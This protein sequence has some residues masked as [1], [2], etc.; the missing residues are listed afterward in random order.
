MIPRRT[1]LA[2]AVAALALPAKPDFDT[3]QTATQMAR[4]LRR[5]RISAREVLEAHLAR[6]ERVNPK[7]NAIVTLVAGQ[8]RQTA[9][10]LD[11]EAAKGRF[12]GPLHGLPVA[13]KDLVE[14]KGI[15][16]TFGSPLFRDYVPTQNAL[17][18]DRMQAAGAVTI[19]KT[20]TPEFGAGSQT[21]NP[22]FG[23]TKNPYDL[24]KTSGGSSG[25][26][27]AALASGMIPIADGSDMG[28]SLRNPAAFCS[29]VGFRG[30]P[31]RVPVPG[32]WSPFS[33]LGPMGR[34][35]E[36]VALL[37]SVLAGPDARAP[38]SIHEP[39]S[40]FAQP[41]ERNCK[42][43]RIAWMPRFAGLPFDR[44]IS[45]VF[46]ARRKD[47]E[48]TGCL[49]EEPESP[50][51]SEA[52][53]VF[54]VFRALSFHQQHAAKAVKGRAQM[55]ATVLEEIDRGSRLT[56]PLIAEAEAK[57]STLYTRF[58]QFMEKYEF[59]V[60]PVT[61]VPAFDANQ[62]Y[63]SEIEGVKLESYIDWMRSCWYITVTGHP[64]ISVPGGYTPEGLPVEIQIV[65]RHQA[66]FA[67][68]QLA[69]VYEQATRP[70]WHRPGV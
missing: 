25:G 62:E 1:I 16:T 42:G 58:G 11:D 47:F 44:R 31:G 32:A 23:S 3:F 26:A 55:K 49:I 38:L 18:V 63:V 69:H 14:T 7:V 53:E 17:I 56:G 28:G 66:D 37:L 54:P 13:H 60:L 65:G 68:L 64:A 22:V 12:A 21:F 52:A 36:D 10:R 30:S 2:G 40:R 33:V 4:D 45:D 29:V 51:F 5:K 57:R 70:L 59:M 20:N 9:A 50:D 15:R 67:V 27:A 48:S 6:I 41:L 46:A 39:G 8:A 43:V 35:V 61:Q 24:S 34:S 19:G